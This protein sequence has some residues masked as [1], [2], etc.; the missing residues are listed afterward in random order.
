M[1]YRTGATNLDHHIKCLYKFL[2]T[3]G[4][5]NKESILFESQSDK[6]LGIIA[7]SARR[8]PQGKVIQQVHQGSK[9]PISMVKRSKLNQNDQA[10]RTPFRRSSASRPTKNL[11]LAKSVEGPSTDG[12]FSSSN[13]H[14]K[15]SKISDNLKDKKLINPPKIECVFIKNQ[16][17]VKKYIDSI[18]IVIA[19]ARTARRVCHHFKLQWV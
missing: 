17:A 7:A 16:I 19:E 10:C 14:I 1:I 9:R 3:Y 15:F 12:S 2:V 5:K 18:S 4:K 8:N 6:C 13:H 11:Q